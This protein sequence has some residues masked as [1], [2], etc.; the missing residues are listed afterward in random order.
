LVD[1]NTSSKTLGLQVLDIEH[2]DIQII[3][4]VPFAISILDD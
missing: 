3:E 1:L 4:F 2:R